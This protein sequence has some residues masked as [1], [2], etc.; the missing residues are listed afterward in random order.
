[1]IDVRI[2]TLPPRRV[3]ALTHTGAYETIGPSFEKVVGAAAMAGLLGSD[4]TTVGIY[5]DNPEVTP[6]ERLHSHACVIV[7]PGALTAPDGFEL[8]D[9]EAGEFAIGV[10]RGPYR[11]LSSSYQWLFGQWL[12]SSG[13]EPGHAPVQEV[14][15]S[16]APSRTPEDQ[17][18]TH[19]CVPLVTQ[20]DDR[21]RH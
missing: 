6:Q 11:T 21:S 12:P 19:I 5:Y 14:Y 17:L 4:T 15:V 13:R 9:L 8:L 16:V 1:M 18:I 10:H 20:G 7:Q 3:L 2:E